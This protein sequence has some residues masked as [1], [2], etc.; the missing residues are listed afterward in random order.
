[1]KNLVT[2]IILFSLLPINGINAQN[3][4]KMNA[5]NK[6]KVYPNP[7]LIGQDLNIKSDIAISNVEI[8]DIIGKQIKLQ[9]SDNFDTKEMSIRLEQ[10]KQGVYIVKIQ[11]QSGEYAI[12]KLLVKNQ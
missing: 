7:L 4:S 6:A 1:M 8:L 2:F 9:E 12:K 5:E 10:C 3:F 11:F